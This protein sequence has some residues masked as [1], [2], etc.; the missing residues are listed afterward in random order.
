MQ[1]R[2]AGWMMRV[3][4]DNP[5]L[6]VGFLNARAEDV[7]RPDETIEITPGELKTEDLLHLWEILAP[8]KYYLSIPYLARNIRIESTQLQ[9]AAEP[10][11]QRTFDYV[12]PS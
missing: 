10:I 5:I 3:M 11:Q 1:H 6:P 7:F 8:N 9:S 2:I 4:E 12:S